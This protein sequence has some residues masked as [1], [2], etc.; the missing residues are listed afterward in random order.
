MYGSRKAGAFL[1]RLFVVWSSQTQSLSLWVLTKMAASD[2]TATH[3][4]FRYRCS[5]P[6]LAE[7][8]INH[9]A[10]PEAMCGYDAGT[11]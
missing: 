8:T 11:V 6:R 9:C 1:L 5:I 3:N 10:G 7:F 4:W 2:L